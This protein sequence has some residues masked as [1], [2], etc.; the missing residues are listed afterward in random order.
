MRVPAAL[1]AAVLLMSGCGNSP[2][3]TVPATGTEPATTTGLIPP[4]VPTEGTRPP[5]AELP[6]AAEPQRAAVPTTPP[7]G[8]QVRVGAAPEGIVVD[9]VTRTVAVATREPFE[10]VL[11]NA[12]TGDITG[13][14][15][16]PGAVRHL[17]LAKPGGPVLV[18]VESAN[19]LVRVELPGGAV[20]P[21]IITG[22]VPH[23]AS[24]APDGTT[25]VANELGGTVSA[26]RDG[27]VVKV[28]TDSVQ[29]AGL[30]PVGDPW[31]CLTSARMI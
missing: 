14:T 5:M 23:D 12:D 31:A 30:A 17:Q 13:R 25:F 7:P 6:G 19:A 22:T 2:V 1:A 15:P 10:L 24:Q 3:E 28:F 21:Q 26:I 20:E 18:P 8:R 29:P 11:M 9:P 16:L 27:R 4:G